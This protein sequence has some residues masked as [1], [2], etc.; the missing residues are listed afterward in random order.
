FGTVMV[1]IFVAPLKVVRIDDH[2]LYVS[3][4][5]REVRIPFSRVGDV[6]DAWLI[7]VRPITI[8]FLTN[9]EFGRQIVFIPKISLSAAFAQH[10]VVD[11]LRH[12]VHRDKAS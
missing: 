10:P 12:L 1:Y 11:E 6:T 3:N 4:Y 5:R 8:G 7:N 2:A 9:T